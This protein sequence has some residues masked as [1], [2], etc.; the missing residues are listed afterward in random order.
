V[1]TEPLFFRDDLGHYYR[2]PEINEVRSADR[3]LKRRGDVLKFGPLR[4]SLGCLW[5]GEV[6]CMLALLRLFQGLG[7]PLEIKTPR[8]CSWLELKRTSLILLGNART[9]SVLKSLDGGTPFTLQARQIENRKPAKDEKRSYRD[10]RFID[11]NMECMT[12][13]ALV[14]RRPGPTPESVVTMIAANHCRGIEGAGYFLSQEERVR[15]V[16]ERLRTRG[17]ALPRC[18]QLVLRVDTIDTT[19][20]VVNA[21]CVAHRVFARNGQ[22]APV[23]KKSGGSPRRSLDE[24]A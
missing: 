7:A 14:T 16:L 22:A 6:H 18:F 17:P 11:G 23:R 15:E 20:E 9:N 24:R 13:Y 8:T 1:Y 19:R 10:S 12:A 5:T 2:D 4:L 3:F 21:E